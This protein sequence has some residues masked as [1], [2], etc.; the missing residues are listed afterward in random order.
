MSFPAGL[1]SENQRQSILA[2]TD[3]DDLGI[4]ALGQVFGSFDALPLQKLWADALGDDLLEIA[5]ASSFNPFALCFLFFLL[6]AEVHGQGFLFGLL[7]GFD[8]RLERLR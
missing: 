2:I 5:N 8:G 1:L 4:R 3:D 7:L 6:Q